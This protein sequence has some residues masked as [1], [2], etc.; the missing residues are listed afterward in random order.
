MLLFA[1]GKPPEFGRFALL[2][3][4]LLAT[5]GT[6]AVCNLPRL[7]TLATSIVLGWTI[8]SG[9]QYINSFM[10][11]TQARTSRVIAAEEIAARSPQRLA[12]LRE[13][14]PYNCPPVDLFNTRM[15]LLPPEASRTRGEWDMLTYP[16]ESIQ[17]SQLLQTPMSWANAQFVIL[18]R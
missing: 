3:N 16:V 12:L 7:S 8:F 17:R 15:L 4:V 1:A 6:I 9:A 5:F 14:A 11:D 18:A 13:P 2:I 10:Q